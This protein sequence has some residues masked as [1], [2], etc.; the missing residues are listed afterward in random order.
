MFDFT[1]IHNMTS[2]WSS[3]PPHPYGCGASQVDD[4]HEEGVPTQCGVTMC[5]CDVGKGLNVSIEKYVAPIVS[6]ASEH[7][8]ETQPPWLNSVLD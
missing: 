6:C 3:A 7:C 4:Q 2:C 8:D 5:G 1:K